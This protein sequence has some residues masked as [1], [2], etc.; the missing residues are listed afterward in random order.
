MSHR[1]L[2]IAFQFLGGALWTGGI[3]YLENLF[4]A[5]RS[6]DLAR[7]RCPEILLLVK[8][9]TPSHVYDTLVPLVDQLLYS[10]VEVASPSFWQRVTRVQNQ[11]RKYQEYRTRLEAYLREQH[12]DLLVGD[13]VGP[14]LR[15]P[16]LTWLPDFQQVHLPDMWQPE[17]IQRRNQYFM[18]LAA[19]ATRILL[20]SQDVLCDYERFAP[21]FIN[22]ARVLRFVAQIPDGLYESDPSW[23]CNHYHLPQRFIFLPDQF[24]KHK[25]HEIVVRALK[26]IKQNHPEVVVV[27]AGNT[28]DFRDPVYFG[29]FMA[30][31]SE[32]N[33][34]ENLIILGIVPHAH[35]FPLIRQ[36]VAVLQPSLFEGWST[37]V[38]EAK[39]VGKQMIL[40]DLAIHREQ[41]PAQS[42]FFDPQGPEALANC[43]V[44]MFERTAPGPDLQLEALAR[45]LYP[46]RTMAFARRFIEIAREVV[47]EQGEKA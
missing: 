15:I 6:S 33:L 14:G 32:E 31:V 40:S 43:I 38:E 22:K 45:E 10:P 2:R 30:T 18:R 17:E 35:V 21:Q 25:N 1:E 34:R 7:E 29:K 11:Q 44:D 20:S 4:R 3:S 5:L 36:S 9:D 23:V 47:P 12:V 8:P 28:H 27:C 16:T 46:K 41:D 37:T 24:W 39:S 19:H 26:S 13:A 42:V